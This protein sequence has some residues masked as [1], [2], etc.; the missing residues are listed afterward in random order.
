VVSFF[1]ETTI[2]QYAQLFMSLCLAT[3]YE[4]MAKTAAA[5][6]ATENKDAA[7]RVRSLGLMQE[8]VP[9][10]WHFEQQGAVK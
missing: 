5:V 6:A 1:Y 4:E 9:G 7:R 8:E 2:D 10:P 3:M